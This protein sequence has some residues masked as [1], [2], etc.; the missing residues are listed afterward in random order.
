MSTEK[1]K[2]RL[3]WLDA[4]KAAALLMVLLSHSMRDEMREVSRTLDVIYRFAYCFQ[5][6]FFFWLT[7]FTYW[8]TRKTG[9]NG[10]ALVKRAKRQLLPWNLYTLFVFLVFS[11]ACLL[12]PLREVLNN[13]GYGPMPFSQYLLMAVQANNPWAYHLWFILVLFLITVLVTGADMLLGKHGKALCA[14]LLGLGFAV[15]I[16]KDGW[17]LGE[18]WRLMEYL[19][20]YVPWFALGMLTCI[21]WDRLCALPGAAIWAWGGLGLAY[22]V[23]RTLFFSGSSGNSLAVESAPLRI[24]LHALAY[25]LLSGLMVLICRLLGRAAGGRTVGKL[26]VLGR[27]SFPVYLFHQPFCCAFLGVLLYGRLH[28]PALLTMAV[29]FISSLLLPYALIKLKNAFLG[30]KNH[31]P[32]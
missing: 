14:V 17:P 11:V 24:L 21:S 30:G 16:A 20:L 19:S 4:A 1:K 6:P 28:V 32:K 10:K 22:A 8:L 2:T 26:A 29:C 23:V 13:A 5:M 12:P 31:D 27:N 7:G 15:W 3:D 18:W 9:A 25:L